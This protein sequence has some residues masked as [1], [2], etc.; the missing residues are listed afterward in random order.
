VAAKVL[1]VAELVAAY[2]RCPGSL[3]VSRPP[4]LIAPA[5]LTIL[6]EEDPGAGQRRDL[7]GD[8]SNRRAA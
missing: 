8:S 3:R 7:L 6:G 4:N 5:R 2:Q 1:A